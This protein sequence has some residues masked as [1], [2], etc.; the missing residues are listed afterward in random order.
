MSAEELTKYKEKLEAEWKN[1]QKQ[2]AALE[3]GKKQVAAQRAQINRESQENAAKAEQLSRQAEARQ[4]TTIVTGTVGAIKEFSLQENWTT[5]KERV[6]H[7]FIANK[8][9]EERKVSL[10]LTLVGSEGYTLLREL[11]A[12]A[13][14]ATK[15]IQALFETMDNHLQ[16]KP[17][18]IMERCKFKECR[19]KEGEDV[20]QYIATLKKLSMYCDFGNNLEDALRDQLVWGIHCENTKKRLLGEGDALTYAR[21]IELATSMDSAKKAA[22]EMGAPRSY[23]GSHVNY[24]AGNR[25]TRQMESTRR[26]SNTTSDAN[27]WC[28]GKKNHSASECR[29]RNYSCNKCKKKGH[30]EAVCKSKMP[31]DSYSKPDRFKNKS[32]R[33]ESQNCL[34]EIEDLSQTLNTL[35]FVSDN[36]IKSVKPVVIDLELN[37]VIVNFE[38]DTGSPISAISVKELKKNKRLSSIKLMR[39]ERTFRSYLG[40]AIIPKGVL[41]VDVKHKSSKAELELF[42][43]PGSSMP[44]VGRE[45]LHALGLV[46][47]GNGA[48][49]VTVNKLIS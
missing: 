48:R 21:A 5:W 22:A 49:E 4:V 2:Q 46:S 8:V 29:Y 25:Y 33:K 1:L 14:P 6:E 12:P 38:I 10:F 34:N 24:V 37:N 27:C 30:L 15:T 39:T 17:S 42:V 45:W 31:R 19:Q 36:V 13:S 44:I 18:V 32:N 35:F 16:P 28:C 26:T 11:C 43:F 20:K 3:E 40:E 47:F 9:E 7:Y 23:G 41:R